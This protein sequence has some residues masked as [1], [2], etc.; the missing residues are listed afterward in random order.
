M[1]E[2]NSLFCIISQICNSAIQTC[3]LDGKIEYRRSYESDIFDQDNV[4]SF[5]IVHNNHT[6]QNGN[7]F[8]F[9]LESNVIMLCF[10]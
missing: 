9:V 8:P 7:L 5:K 10:K 6:K 3:I 1:E 4:Y 2:K